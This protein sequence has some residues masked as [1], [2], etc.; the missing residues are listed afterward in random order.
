MGYIMPSA[1]YFAAKAAMSLKVLYPR[2]M[3][4]GK[5]ALRAKKSPARLKE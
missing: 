2:T 5:T 3:K 4:N 1:D